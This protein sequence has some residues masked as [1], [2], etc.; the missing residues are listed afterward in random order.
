MCVLACKKTH[1]YVNMRERERY[2]YIIYTNI[3]HD[4]HT[5]TA[6]TDHIYKS[7]ETLTDLT[8]FAIAN[9]LPQGQSTCIAC[10]KS[11]HIIP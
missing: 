3:I 5:Y 2:I 7:L 11:T 6:N 10:N 8:L 9:L 1:K 4:I